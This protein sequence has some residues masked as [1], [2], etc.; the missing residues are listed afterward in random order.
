LVKKDG[1]LR[2]SPVAPIALIQWDLIPRTVTLEMV[3]G[4]R[5]VGVQTFVV[6]VYGSDE[7]EES[8]NVSCHRDP[9]QR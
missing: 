1:A 5:E 3:F 7:R 4:V 8:K 6:D 2:V 9:Y